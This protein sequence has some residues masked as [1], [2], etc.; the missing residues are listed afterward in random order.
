MKCGYIQAVTVRDPCTISRCTRSARNKD[1]SPGKRRNVACGLQQANRIM[2]ASATRD[3]LEWRASWG[4]PRPNSPRA[5]S[6]PGAR[7]LLGAVVR[8]DI[9]NHDELH[10][11]LSDAGCSKRDIFSD[12]V[13]L[14]IAATG[15]KR[16]E[17]RSNG[18]RHPIATSLRLARS[19]N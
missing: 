6:R 13:I 7:G 18:R 12:G 15:R 1:L 5:T 4:T 19:P 17:R 9:A 16:L 14:A 10:V 8:A 3:G 2:L 11:L